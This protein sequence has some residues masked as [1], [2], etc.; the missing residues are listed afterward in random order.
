MA[1]RHALLCR[2]FGVSCVLGLFSVQADDLA[3]PSAYEGKPIAEVRYEPPSQPVARADLARLVPFRPGIPLHL[4][5]VR[6]AIKRLYG[7]GQYSNIAIA[8]EPA[9]N[10]VVL[11]IRTTEQYFVGPVEV[12]GKVKSPPNE[13]QLAG[14]TRL[15][16]G[17]PYYD[18]NLQAAIKGIND[19][20]N[21]NG[22]YLAKVEP[23]IRRD[24]EHN[25]IALTFKVDSGKRARLTLPTITGDTRIPSEELAKAAKY[26]GWFRWKLATDD[27]V[28]RGLRNIQ[29]RYT[30]QDRLTATVDLDHQD[31]IAATNRV[32]PTINAEGGPKVKITV[33]EAKVSKGT[34]RK[35]VP[36]FDEQTVNHDLLVNGAR[37]LRDYFQIQGYFDVQ[38][39]FRSTQ[40]SPDSEEI[41]YIISLGPRHRLVKVDIQGNRYFK[42]ADIR[43]R[44]F[45]QPA[46]TLRLRHGRFSE[47]FE[48]RDKDAIQA[49]YKD[50]GFRDVNVSFA[51]TDEYQRKK[52]DVA[53]TVSIVEG[54]QYKVSSLTIDGMV[55][56][57][58][59]KVMP[60]M[61]SV[62]GEPFS[63]TSVAMDRDAIL[64]AYQ[65]AGFP[66]AELQWRVVPGP[67]P[68][69]MGVV[70]TVTEGEPRSVRGVLIYGNHTTRHRLI[71]PNVTIHSGD[72]L[73]W[74]AMG[75]MQR[76]LYNLG[77]FDKVD[78]AIQN[79]NGDTE[80]KYVIYQ[81]TEG[82]R[83]Y[84]AI[85]LGLEAANIGGSQ[86][87]LNNPGGAAGIAP[88][89]DL[90]LTRLNLWGLGHSIVFKGRYSTLDRRVSLNYLAPRFHNVQGRDISVTALYDNTRDVL[91]FTAVRYEGSAQLSQRLSK[92]TTLMWRYTWRD[93]KVDPATLKINPELIPLVSQA[94]RI[95]MVSGNLI[96]D[97]RD[98]PLNAHRGYYNSVD[99]GLVDHTL[100]G[101]KNFLRLLG[102]NSFYKK[103]TGNWVLASNTQFGVIRP[104]QTGGVNAFDYVPLPE[105]FFGGGTNSQRGFPDNQAGPRDLTT[106]FPLG[107]DALLFH[108]TEVRFPL[109]GD[110]ISGV[111]FHDMGNIYTDVG[112]ISFRV[113]QNG[114]SDFNYMV[115]AA[116]FGIRYRTPLG[117]I[118]LDLAYS[119]N[120]PMFNGL[121][122]SFQDL[123]AGTAT[124]AV[125]S[126]SHFQFFFSIGQAF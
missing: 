120:P 70:Y 80:N 65:T 118:R 103:L 78:M 22:L 111:F 5:D 43:E 88:R 107:G 1:L 46:G 124:P 10:G 92:A 12:T 74:N 104:F 44:M 45:L 48:K 17:T 4:A 15:E 42:T 53:V 7:T 57:D 16:L 121:K 123:L 58:K 49:L 40:P 75:L 101:N 47:G 82:H 83:Y 56:V 106:G 79:P 54:P 122:G 114:L 55:S 81:L 20:L 95:A 36:V 11:V 105:H 26:K 23:E 35:Y 21:R 62:T 71:D 28:Q 18:E 30:K 41:T 109:I 125:Q 3:P 85:G 68:N 93:V 2:V 13:G 37:N 38:V 27:E 52:G 91:T 77:V 100:G 72:P 59:A 84:A 112:S 119:I 31:Y 117:P 108:Q 9:A 69:Q 73:S 29:N 113:H 51:E 116:G 50:N 25:Q 99:L 87:S 24:A 115:H 110:N 8:T 96:Q 94:A 34:L 90:E 19:L 39:D 64:D 66:D 86:T 6:E 89:G 61:S 33:K 60:R 97:R 102:R 98:D 76:R 67:G 32:K 126:V 63:E 14:A